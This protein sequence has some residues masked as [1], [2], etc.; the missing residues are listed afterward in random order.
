VISS[1]SR[2]FSAPAKVPKDIVNI[3]SGAIKKVVASEEHKKKMADM[4]LTL[5][6]MDAAQYAK[7]WE[8]YETTVKDLMALAK[9]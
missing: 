4:G 9:E 6:Y 7:F 8:E 2:G 3:L 1:S 5:K